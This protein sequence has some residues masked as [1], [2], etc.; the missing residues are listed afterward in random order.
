ML[1]DGFRDRHEDHAGLLQLFLEGRDDGHRIE[2]GVDGDLGLFDAGEDFLLAQRNAELLVGPQQFRVNLVERLRAALVLRSG[3]VI[4]VVE[5]DLR[6]VDARP[7]GLFH[8]QPAA[9]G[10]EAPFEHPVGLALLG[11]DEADDVLGKPLRG[12]VHLDLRLEAVL[13]LV[14]V[15]LTDL[16]DRFLHRRHIVLQSRRIQGPAV[17]QRLAGPPAAYVSAKG[18]FSHLLASENLR[19]RK[20]PVRPPVAAP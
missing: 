1:A 10:L 14:D 8:G 19:S 13:V 20:I 2:D 3:I 6:I 5:V 18:G 15:N 16:I 7:G 17:C 9:I 4:K 12:L 11:R